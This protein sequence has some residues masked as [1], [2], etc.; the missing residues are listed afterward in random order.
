MHAATE[1]VLAALLLSRC[2]GQGVAPGVRASLRGGDPS[3]LKKIVRGSVDV[4]K[5][6]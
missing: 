1:L 6:S 5:V 4:E 3:A 2:C